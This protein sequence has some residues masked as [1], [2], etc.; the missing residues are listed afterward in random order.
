METTPLCPSCGKPLPSNALKGLCPECLMKGAFPTGADTDAPEKPPRFVPPKPEELARYFPQLEIL[1]FIGQGGMGAVYKV[2]QKE[3]DRIVALKILP[4]GIGSDPAFAGRFAREAKALAKLNHPGIVTLYEFGNVGQASRLSHTSENHPAGSVPQGGDPDK[5]ETG[6]TPVLLFYFLMEF[7]DGVTLRQLL[8]AGRVSPREA[9]AIVPQICDALQFAHDQGIVH[10]DI[11]PE[12]ILLD[13]RGRVKVADFGLAKIVGNEGRAELPLGPDAQQRVPTDSLTDAG[14]VMGTPNYMAPEQIEHPADV[15]NRADIYAL[16]VVFYQMLTGELPGKPIVPPSQSGGKVQIDVRLDEVVL[17]ALEKKPE[18]RYRQVSEVKTM[19]ETIVSD[20][21]Q[22]EAR[23]QKPEFSQT[24]KSCICYVSSPKHVRS[25]WG[26][27]IYIYEGKGTIQLTAQ[28]LIFSSPEETIRIPLRS[29]RNLRMGHYPRTAKPIRLDYISITYEEAGNLQ[30]RLFT[31]GWSGFVPVWKTNPLV[32]EWFDAIQ[33]AVRK[34][35]VA[36]FVAPPLAQD[37]KN[38][39]GSISKSRFGRTVLVGV[40]NGKR[41][42]NWTGVIQM[43]VVIYAASL[44]GT[45][46]AFGRWVPFQDLIWSLSGAVTL[47]TAALVQME[48]KKPL[49]RLQPGSSRRPQRQSEAAAGEEARLEKLEKKKSFWGMLFAV[50]IIACL[51]LFPVYLGFKLHHL[52]STIDKIIATESDDAGARQ[53]NGPPFVARLNQ[54]EVELVAIGNQP[55]TNPGCWLPN[56]EPSAAPFPAKYFGSMDSWAE[57]K[58]TKKIAFR[59]HNEGSDG[60]S[61]P[62][63]RVN[64]ESGVGTAGSGTQ[65]PD[66]RSSEMNFVQL[67][68]CPSNATTMNISLGVANS[69]WETATT[70]HSG[71]GGSGSANGEWNATFQAVAGKSGDVAVGCTYS[72]NPDWESRMAYVDGAGKLIPIQENSSHAGDTHQ[73]GATLL[74]SSNDFAQIKEFQLQRRKYQWV[75]FRNVSLQPGHKTKVEVKENLVK[76]IARIEPWSGASD[77]APVFDT[78]IERV[79]TNAFSFETGKQRGISWLDGKG[80]GVSRNLQEKEK[81]LSEHDVDLFTDD[82]RILYG[83][84]MKAIAADWESPVLNGRLAERLQ[85]T[86]RFALFAV[87]W[88][89][90]ATKPAFWFETRKGLKGI[91]Q[92]TGFTDNPSGVK[93]R[94]KLAQN[95]GNQPTNTPSISATHLGEVPKLRYLEWDEDW[96]T[97]YPVGVHYPDGSLVTNKQELA[98]LEYVSPGMMSDVS[99]RPDLAKQH[100]HF[101]HLWFSH[102]LFDD[103]RFAE[104][105]LADENG[106]NPTDPYSSRVGEIKAAEPQNGNFDWLVESLMCGAGTNIPAKVTIRL[107]YTVGPLEQIQEIPSDYNGYLAIL[108]GSQLGSI[109]QDARGNTLVTIGVNPQTLKT[110][111]YCV[112]AVTKDGRKLMSGGG[113]SGNSDGSGPQLSRFYFQVPLSDVAKFIIGTRPIRTMEWTN[114]VLPRN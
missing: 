113:I 56:G 41:E 37:Q 65:G 107:R 92:I 25:F 29:I 80:I 7:V 2:R 91:L 36:T 18:L 21:K 1:E 76:P 31:P 111:Q 10:R 90:Q 50:F 24:N 104:V 49:E 47:I 12:N 15:D 38:V 14:K 99:G 81:F 32:A 43:W 58:L 86:N 46:I 9:L 22:P 17:R 26:R 77:A 33:I 59:I 74:I 97:N 95:G 23:S 93:I 98:W 64:N 71:L 57:G 105:T 55:W 88:G 89:Q 45:Y 112:Q 87:A 66:A 79:V 75:E 8:N 101:L 69:A 19:V 27:F 114:V 54:A 53:L 70:L 6:A 34:P 106:K 100:P 40:C 13:R 48:L 3:L 60:V 5:M 103:S 20:P 109:G 62:V 67:I 39:S 94:Y 84:D 96:K 68:C 30:T 82:G 52:F 63:C 16:G 11:K 44:V 4:P 42:I 110:R 78:V 108:G 61:Y 85:S 72:K 83:M 35:D 51:V 28:E 73:T 102:P